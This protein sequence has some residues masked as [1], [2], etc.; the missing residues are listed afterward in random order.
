MYIMSKKNCSNINKLFGIGLDRRLNDFYL[1]I[2]DIINNSK[3]KVIAVDVP[4]G[5]DADS[6]RPLGN[7]P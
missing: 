6:G 4:S 2:I 7:A 3:K 1:K 5:L